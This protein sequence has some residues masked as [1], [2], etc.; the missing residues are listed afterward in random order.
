[1]PGKSFELTER[2]CPRPNQEQESGPRRDGT[3][4]KSARKRQC[5]RRLDRRGGGTPAVFQK[6]VFVLREEGL[7][8]PLK[9]PLDRLRRGYFSDKC[10]LSPGMWF[11]VRNKSFQTAFR[12]NGGY[13]GSLTGGSLSW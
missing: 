8:T 12:E 5:V 6:S 3:L 13:L 10:T 7:G 1:I 11:R 4:N 9:K 2:L